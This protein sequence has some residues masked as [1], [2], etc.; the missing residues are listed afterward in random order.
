MRM[1]GEAAVIKYKARQWFGGI[2][3]F[4]LIMTWCKCLVRKSSAQFAGSHP[5]V[6]FLTSEFGL[7]DRDSRNLPS[8]LPDLQNTRRI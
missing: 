2:A 3:P 4:H 6:L 7:L 5:S 8:S 1:T